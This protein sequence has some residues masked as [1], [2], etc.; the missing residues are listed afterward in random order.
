MTQQPTPYNPVPPQAPAAQPPMPQAGQMPPPTGGPVPVQPGQ[1]PMPPAQPMPGQMAPQ[2]GM[3]VAPAAPAA[4]PMP[5]M[6]P[7]APAPAM[8]PMQHAQVAPP[9]QMPTVEP[10]SDGGEKALP[11]ISIQAFCDRS[12]TAGVVHE[13]TR[14]WRM[15]RANLKIFMG[16]L[17]AAIEYYHKEST[18][19]LILIES[20]MRGQE[21]FAQ[22]EQLA[23]VCDE[24]TRVMIIGAAN[25]IKL[26]RQLI[27]RGVS[28]YIV[29]PF[30]P[31]TLIRSISEL[32]NDPEKPF[33]GRVTA[34]FG[35][36]GGVGS[37]TL[38]H[39]VAWCLSETLSQ[40]TA[41]V[42][43]DASWGTTGLDFA[44]DATQGL[45]EAL[46]EPDRLDET[47]LDRIMLRHTDKLSILPTSGS[48]ANRPNMDSHAYETVVTGVRAISPLTILDM[49]HFWTDWT[50]NILT[51]VDDIVI[52]C[53]PDLANLRNTKNLVDF[54][55]AERPNDLPPILIL[56]KTGRTKGNEISV[57]EFGSAVGIDP[58]LV[59]GFEPDVFIEAANDGKML[60]EV[61][62]TEKT[63]EGLI[64]IANRLKTGSFSSVQPL[65]GRGKGLSLLSKKGPEPVG[66]GDKK[67]LFS[68]L[69][70]R[71]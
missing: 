11:K 26:Y 17:P 45:E 20:G 53:V 54:L 39:N 70:K 71:K 5:N 8:A 58:A 7:Q 25:D 23:S 50:T 65:G 38:A 42:D 24:D 60:T 15:K 16:G 69:K 30:H 13:M 40:E 57:K 46:A 4:P 9:Y 34:F 27:D 6:T 10:V 52:T 31:L 22:L 41:L 14:D 2:H 67:S 63:I 32:Y 36:K 59:I 56:N 55:K 51:G 21:L 62:N 47:L 64:Y 28:D 43:L 35:A 19:N 68:R 12:E 1:P 61:K 37:S 44:Y 66:S 49:P 29:P 48:L 3:P 18:P 33:T